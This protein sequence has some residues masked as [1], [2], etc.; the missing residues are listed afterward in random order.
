M[1]TQQAD[2]IASRAGVLARNAREYPPCCQMVR[3]WLRLA[4]RQAVKQGN[5][6]LE[7]TVKKAAEGILQ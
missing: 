1:Q 3:S 7:A 6:T 5:G 4:Q 2:F